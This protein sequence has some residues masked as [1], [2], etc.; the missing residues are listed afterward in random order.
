VPLT[1]RETGENGRVESKRLGVLTLR[2][3][4]RRVK[5]SSLAGKETIEKVGVF[6]A[7]AS[8][9]LSKIIHDRFDLLT[10]LPKR[11]ELA[12]QLN[13]MKGNFSMLMIDI[14]HFKRINDN[15]KYGHDVGDIVLRRFAQIINTSIRSNVETR[16]DD[17]VVDLLF[18]YGGEEFVIL[19]PNLD[20]KKSI[21]I[22]ERLRAKVESTPIDIGGEEIHITCSIGVVDAKTA[23][24]NGGR[25]PEK[26]LGE[27]MITIADRAMFSAK[28]NGR[29]GVVTAKRV[30]DEIFYTE[31]HPN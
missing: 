28:D 30:D 7:G 18:R 10:G 17:N 16:R 2:G 9:I 22:A 23:K 11:P 12:G 21:G 8:R 3:D 13:Q 25:P 19:L 15:P 5:R 26:H 24:G 27:I 1:I 6:I 31:C 29:N 4:E 14:D 20:S